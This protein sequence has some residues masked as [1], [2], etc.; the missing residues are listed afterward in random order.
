MGHRSK[1]K[2]THK[3]TK[4]ITGLNASDRY[5]QADFPFDCCEPLLP[6][7]DTLPQTSPMVKA[8]VMASRFPHK[9]S[10]NDV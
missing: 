9:Q 3:S 1:K 5:R 8:R 10:D 2:E 4:R 6:G 7:R